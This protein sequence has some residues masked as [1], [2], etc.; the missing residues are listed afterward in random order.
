MGSRSSEKKSMTS[1]RAPGARFNRKTAC[2]PKA[3]FRKP[4]ALGP[5]TGPSVAHTENIA[6][7]I[8][9]LAGGNSRTINTKAMGISTPPKKPCRARNVTICPRLVAKAQPTEKARNRTA[10]PSR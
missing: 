2:Q 5:T 6:M 3:L 10:L 8:T 4:P 9:T 7:P 1:I